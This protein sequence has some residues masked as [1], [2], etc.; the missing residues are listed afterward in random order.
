MTHF[1]NE[2]LTNPFGMLTKGAEPAS[3]LADIVAETLGV[4]P[5]FAQGG[6]PLL[7]FVLSAFCLLGFIM[8]VRRSQAMATNGQGGGGRGT[9]SI[10][11]LLVGLVAFMLAITLKVA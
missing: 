1:I 8:L 2:A 6:L 11:L 3:R 5:E 10:L 4:A 9:F 7:L